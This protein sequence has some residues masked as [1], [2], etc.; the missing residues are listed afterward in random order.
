MIGTD[1]ANLSHFCIAN[2]LVK[3]RNVVKCSRR[4][5][6][7][8]KVNRKIIIVFTKQISLV[9]IHPLPT[10]NIGVDVLCML[11]SYLHHCTHNGKQEIRG[12]QRYHQIDGILQPPL[13]NIFNLHP[14]THPRVAVASKKVST[15]RADCLPPL[16]NLKYR[17]CRS[18]PQVESFVRQLIHSKKSISR[19]PIRSSTQH[20]WLL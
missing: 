5:R 12:Y 9:N 10:F 19:F 13:R 16:Y 20:S 8:D 3:F 2:N 11:R 17:N 14:Y 1:R 18:R 6:V 15:L 7:R 4:I